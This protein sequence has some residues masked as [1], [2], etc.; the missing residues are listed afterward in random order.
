MRPLLSIKMLFRSPIKTLVTFLLLTAISFAL[1]ARVLDYAATSREFEQAVQNY[2]G[3]GVIEV[4]PPVYTDIGTPRYLMGTW[5]N[6]DNTDGTWEDTRYAAL[7]AEQMAAMADLPYVTA[8][9][10]RYLTAGISP[11]FKRI[12]AKRTFYDYASRHVFEG[13]FKGL[14]HEFS[15][16]STLLSDLSLFAVESD[17]GLLNYEGLTT[18]TITDIAPLTS[19]PL[20]ANSVNHFPLSFYIL[21]QE[22]LAGRFPN[23]LPDFN[24]NTFYTWNQ[25]IYGGKIYPERFGEFYGGKL[26]KRNTFSTTLPLGFDTAE[27]LVPGERY[28]I[29][30]G[31]LYI[32]V[33]QV[34]GLAP[35]SHAWAGDAAAEYW[36]DILVPLAGLS[37]NYLELPEFEGYRQLIAIT[38]Q[39]YYTFDVVY[40]D[41]MAAIPRFNERKL[42]IVKGRP[43]TAEDAGAEVCVISSDLA[44]RYGL[45]IG[46]SFPLGLCDKLFEQHAGLGAVAVTRGR[47]STPVQDVNLEIVGLYRDY[48]SEN[49]Q[50]LTAHHSYSANTV[51]VPLELLPASAQVV[52]AVIKPGS[53]SF[54]I[55]DPRNI[56]AFMKESAPL[57]ESM[58]LTLT[59][60]DGGWATVANQFGLTAK[61]SLIAITELLVALLAT[62]ALLVHLFIGQRRHEYAV[63]RA[64]GCAKPRANLA[65][66]LPFCLLGLGAVAISSVAAWFNLARTTTVALPLNLYLLCVGG[67]LALLTLAAWF[68]LWQVSR[69]P[70][71]ALLQASARPQAN[72]KKNKADLVRLAPPLLEYRTFD[73]KNMPPVSAQRHQNPLRQ[74]INYTW[75]NIRRGAHKSLLTLLVAALLFA[76]SG[77]FAAV[78]QAT[79]E[80]YETFTVKAVFMGQLGNELIKD[81]SAISYLQ[82]PYLEAANLSAWLSSLEVNLGVCNQPQR[83][84]N[85]QIEITYAEP[86]EAAM[87]NNDE[88]VCLADSRL[89]EELGLQLNDVITLTNTVE[90]PETGNYETLEADFT[91]IG[92]ING[93]DGPL[94][95]LVI[96]PGAAHKALYKDSATISFAEYV[97]TDNHMTAELRTLV[98]SRFLSNEVEFA[99]NTDDLD[100]IGNNLS[101]LD[102]FFPVVVAV[103]TV[104]AGLLPGLLILQSAKEASLLRI[105]GTSK[106]QTRSIL[107]L[108]QMLLFVFGLALGMGVLLLGNGSARLAAIAQQLSLSAGLYGLSCLVASLLGCWIVTRRNVLELLQMKE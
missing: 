51:F 61:I 42:G 73:L 62:A 15:S 89:L 19:D 72:A 47:F 28:L 39:D 68:G 54:S 1:F 69:I 3:V 6:P 88:L 41:D 7:T 93:L 82:D 21:K 12:D 26:D 71:L 90:N 46:D 103:L 83:L 23:G 24:I 87:M 57:I 25:K 18:L 104:I 81:I 4:A 74:V 11:E 106:L 30:V 67:E 86:Y 99:M 66:L 22:E 59:L 44:Q 60:S 58:G 55:G 35:T 107:L 10:T 16:L 77:Q 53:F 92:S 17:P 84:F 31:Y 49:A 64:T 5:Y 108:Q 8:T 98:N 79:R 36:C 29:V 45:N 76:A 78:R 14:R 40:T 33:P 95:E 32:L 96:P 52:D 80:L 13:I 94:R 100:R 97:L 75:R 91:V 27:R 34:S 48:D 56:P 37:E 101:L 105:L 20:P 38:N 70:P 65:L 50:G 85:P 9:S 43:L 63:M 102:Y 2:R